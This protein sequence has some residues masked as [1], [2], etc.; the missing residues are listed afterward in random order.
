MAWKTPG[1]ARTWTPAESPL[2]SSSVGYRGAVFPHF[3][4]PPGR[5]IHGDKTA[6]LWGSKGPHPFRFRTQEA[7]G[8]LAQS[9]PHYCSIPQIN[10]QSPK[11]VLLTPA[12]RVRRSSSATGQAWTLS[13]VPLQTD[14]T[15]DSQQLHARFFASLR[16]ELSTSEWSQLTRPELQ[17]VLLGEET[18]LHSLHARKAGL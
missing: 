4:I 14:V 6:V 10:G 2:G 3:P 13:Q 9:P 18:I 8:T 1:V 16:S 12:S 17:N 15:T 7:H 11:E 5:L